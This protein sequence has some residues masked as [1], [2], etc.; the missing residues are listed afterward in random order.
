MVSLSINLLTGIPVQRATTEAIS[1]TSTS[2]F[3]KRSFSG[4]LL[5]SSLKAANFFSFSGISP[6]CN[7]AALARSPSLEARSSSAFCDSIKALTS[8]TLE[9]RSF[10]FCH[11]LSKSLAFCFNSLISVSISFLRKLA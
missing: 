9:I 2:S 6:Y 8:F 3:N 1:S 5:I 4:I 7:F 11:L 10:S